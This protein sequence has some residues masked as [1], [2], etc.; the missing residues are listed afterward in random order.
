MKNE[1]KRLVLFRFSFNSL[2]GAWKI[3]GMT[4]QSS[5]VSQQSWCVRVKINKRSF[6]PF[7][8]PDLVLEC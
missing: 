2:F 6:E 5:F 1:R 8:C 7:S 3:V 4:Q